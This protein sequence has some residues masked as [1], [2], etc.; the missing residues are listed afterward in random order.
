M[1]TR[2]TMRLPAAFLIGHSCSECRSAAGKWAQRTVAPLRG[3]TLLIAGLGKTGQA[4][5]ARGK[6]FGMTVIGTR[7]HPQS[8]DKLDAFGSASELPQL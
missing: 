7:A 3:R 4:V 6:A 5:A 1:A 2:H 8:M